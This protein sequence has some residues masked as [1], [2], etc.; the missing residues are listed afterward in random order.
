[1]RTLPDLEEG[2]V[3]LTIPFESVFSVFA[4]N[5]DK[6]WWF[7]QYEG[8]SGWISAEFIALTSACDDLPPRR[9]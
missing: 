6:T 4:P 5:E 9:P 2:D 1:M 3:I 7:G 8:E